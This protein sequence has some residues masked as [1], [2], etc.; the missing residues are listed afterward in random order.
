MKRDDSM[1]RRLRAQA[2]AYQPEVPTGLRRRVMSAMAGVEVGSSRSR[3]AGWRWMSVA[4]VGVAALVVALVMRGRP[5]HGPVVQTTPQKGPR[6]TLPDTSVAI[7][8]DPVTLA[9]RYIDRPLEGEV[10]RLLVGL[11]QARDTVVRVLPA[12]VKRERA[13]GTRPAGVG[14]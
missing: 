4:G 9:R 6:V 12:P 7:V 5:V 11:E 8:G 10:D 13:A 2:E 3:A 1:V 14:A